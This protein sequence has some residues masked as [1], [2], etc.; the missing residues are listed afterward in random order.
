MVSTIISFLSKAKLKARSASADIQAGTDSPSPKIFDLKISFPPPEARIKDVEIGV[1]FNGSYELRRVV[2]TDEHV[3][4]AEVN[5]EFIID[6]IPLVDILSVDDLDGVTTDTSV[7]EES[8]N[9]AY[10]ASLETVASTLSAF[11][12]RTVR[13]GYNCGRKY[14]LQAKSDRQCDELIK[15]LK[16]QAAAVATQHLI[17]TKTALE[18][19]QDTVRGF[20]DSPGFQ[21][22]SA[23]LILSALVMSAVEAQLGDAVV[24]DGSARQQLDLGNT[25]ITLLFAVELLI[26]LYAHWW[27]EFFAYRMNVWDLFVVTLSVASLGPLETAMP[28]QASRDIHRHRHRQTQAQAQT[29]TSTHA[30]AHAHTQNKRGR[31]R[32]GEGA[33]ER[34]TPAQILR[35]FRV[36]R[37]LRVLKIFVRLP[38]LKKIIS[39]LSHSI[40]PMLNAFLIVLVMMAM[41]AT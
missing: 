1:L 5:Q 41:C 11:Q 12:I 26:N 31:Q 9:L 23:A 18:R 40:V 15:I 4:F 24:A 27:R 25:I 22:A 13:T 8:Q 21:I 19:S 14:C 33:S 16:R 6:F 30:H 37:T 36:I 2:V 10:I 32:A 34:A 3:I 7:V 38:E 28:I 29:Q 35:F 17:T 39:A 20:F